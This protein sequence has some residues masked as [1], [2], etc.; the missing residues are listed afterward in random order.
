MIDRVDEHVRQFNAAVESGEWGPFVDRFAADASM[1]FVNV[2]TGPYLG[3]AAI[4]AAYRDSP[5]DDTL[6]VREV[7]SDGDVDT[8]AVD[9]TRGGAGVMTLEWTAAGLVGRLVVE[10]T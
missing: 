4:A 3:R 9:W 6:A 10:F 1:E 5:P 8:V 7:R 2:P